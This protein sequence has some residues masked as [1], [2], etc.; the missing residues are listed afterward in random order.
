MRFV[1]AV[2]HGAHITRAYVQFAVEQAHTEATVVSIEGEASDN[3][4]AFVNTSHNIVNRLR[5]LNHVSWTLPAW[6]TAGVAGLDQRTPDLSAVIQEIVDRSGWASGN[7]L[8]LIVTGS[9]IHPALS[10]EG[11]AAAAPLLHVEYAQ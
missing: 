6:P 4:P 2:P 11:K 7:R 3:A 1:L 10:F 9:G 8:V 5:T